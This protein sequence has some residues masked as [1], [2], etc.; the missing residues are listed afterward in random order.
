[1]LAGVALNVL[2]SR[3]FDHHRTPIRPGA[4]S[5]VLVT[6][7][8]SARSRN[9]MYLGM[10]LI[11]AGTALALGDAWALVVLP[12]FVAWLDRLVRWEETLLEQA[13]GE[14]YHAY[15]TRVRRWL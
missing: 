12:L 6:E 15:R 7:G 3:L 5:T 4:R 1:M 10:A 8:A 11:V 9:P 14:R 13:F 2:A